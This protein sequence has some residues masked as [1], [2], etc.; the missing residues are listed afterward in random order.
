ME[1]EGVRAVLRNVDTGKEYVITP[2]RGI[3]ASPADSGMP[4]AKGSGRGSD[5]PYNSRDIRAALEER[6]GMD[7]VRST[8]VPPLSKPNVK[9][10]GQHKTIELPDGS[11][12]RI[13]FD[14]KGFPIFD[15]VAKIDTQLDIDKFRMK[16]Y[17]GQLRMATRNLRAQ[18]NA[19]KVSA[20]QFTSAQLKAINSGLDKIPGYT[21]HHHQNTGRMQLVPQDIHSGARHV[22]WE[23]TS[24]GQ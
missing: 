20:S 7:A 24:K 16:S 8:T 14:Q 4:A 2:N 13:V 23:S 21:W 11:T 10:A 19:G 1:C 9:L 6:Y 18:V 15:D 22:G 5:L 3:S 12:T 17:D